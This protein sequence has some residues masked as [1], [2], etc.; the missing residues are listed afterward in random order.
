MGV[1]RC[2]GTD[3]LIIGGGRVEKILKNGENRFFVLVERKKVFVFKPMKNKMFVVT[4][5]NLTS[6]TLVSFVV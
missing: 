3:H 2:F 4:P 5:T 1:T 6:Y